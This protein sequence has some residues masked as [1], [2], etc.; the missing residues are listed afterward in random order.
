MKRKFKVGDRVRIRAWDDMVAEY[1]LDCDGDIN[2]RPSFVRGMR[3]LCGKT[4]TITEKPMY[5]DGQSIRFKL[6]FDDTSKDVNW[7]YSA[8]ML[9]LVKKSDETIVI[10]RDGAEVI[11]MD[12]R[13]GHTAKAKCS[14]D[15]EFDFSVGAKLALERLFEK[16][17]QYLNCR[18][19]C[20]ETK[21]YSLWTV[22]KIYDVKN[23]I[24]RNDN[25]FAYPQDGESPYEDAN[26]IKH[27]GWSFDDA[28]HN[29]ENTFIVIRE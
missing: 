6:A 11:A 17:K 27:A 28:R 1:G 19:V 24:F 12:K 26:D 14:P 15:D 9:E 16:P 8:D 18:A 23:G 4:A 22:G 13:D 20:A 25:G 2:I 7:N 29:P 21:S 3:S 10:R 5:C